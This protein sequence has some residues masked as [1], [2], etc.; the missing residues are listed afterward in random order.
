VEYGALCMLQNKR[1]GA[2]VAH[3]IHLGGTVGKQKSAC[4]V[5][6][7]WV[8]FKTCSYN[9]ISLLRSPDH[10]RRRSPKIRQCLQR[11][12]QSVPTTKLQMSFKH[13]KE[14]TDP[15]MDPMLVNP[16]PALCSPL[17]GHTC[18]TRITRLGSRSGVPGQDMG[19][20]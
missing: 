12:K 6:Y 11:L 20:T 15:E 1:A 4:N 5:S 2:S 14:L 16:I 9:S 19:C 7:K 8:K 3:L 10:R 13:Y 17:A 18:C